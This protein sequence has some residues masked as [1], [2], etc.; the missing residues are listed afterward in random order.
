MVE[1]G[2]RGCGFLKDR[3]HDASTLFADTTLKE[4]RKLLHI[5][6]KAGLTV[7]C[8]RTM[9][10]GGEGG[11]VAQGFVER[12]LPATSYNYPRFEW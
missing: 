5:Q 8:M 12:D 3:R 7:L 2:V 6:T 11:Y 10:N 4:A 9:Y 1:G